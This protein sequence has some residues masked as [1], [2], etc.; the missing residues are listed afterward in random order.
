MFDVD[1]PSPK[2]C[3]QILVTN[4]G[5]TQALKKQLKILTQKRPNPANA[6]KLVG[7]FYLN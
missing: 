4:D 3:R 2:E 6:F 5:R 7:G 1:Y